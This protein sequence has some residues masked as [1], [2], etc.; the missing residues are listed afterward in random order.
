MDVHADELFDF[1]ANFVPATPQIALRNRLE[2]S[3]KQ[4]TRESLP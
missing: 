1:P 2:D 3:V 4:T